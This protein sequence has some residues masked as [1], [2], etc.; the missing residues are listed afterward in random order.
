MGEVLYLIIVTCVPTGIA[1]AGFWMFA[2][3]RYEYNE[4]VRSWRRFAALFAP[5]AISIILIAELARL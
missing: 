5:S 2:R 4:A 3:R 1:L